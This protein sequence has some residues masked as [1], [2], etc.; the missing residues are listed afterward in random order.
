MKH[1]F[2]CL[3]V[4]F[5]FLFMFVGSFSFASVS[6][7]NFSEFEYN[8]NI[9][10][11]VDW[12][13]DTAFKKT[14]QVYETDLINLNNQNRIDNF[15]LFKTCL[16]D[17]TTYISYYTPC[18]YNGN[19]NKYNGNSSTNGKFN[20]FQINFSNN[21]N[22]NG[23]V[24]YSFQ[25]YYMND[26][27]NCIKSNL[28]S[29]LSINGSANPSTSLSS[30]KY[31]Y[32]NEK[33]YVT[34]NKNT[35]IPP[36]INLKFIPVSNT[37]KNISGIPFYIQ[38]FWRYETNFHIGNIQDF[39]SN[40]SYSGYALLLINGQ[41]QTSDVSLYIAPDG[42]VYVYTSNLLYNQGYAF[43]FFN[44]DLETDI[45]NF[46]FIPYGQTSGDIDSSGDYVY[47]GNDNNNNVPIINQINEN[48][49]FWKNTYDS[50]FA[51]NSGDATEVYNM[52]AS[53]FPSGESPVS[54]Y[55]T[56]FGSLNNEPDD[57]IIRWDSIPFNMSIGG[58][59]TTFSG[60]F[61]QS[62]DI[63]FSELTRTN[64][65]FGIVHFWIRTLATISFLFIA[66]MTLYKCFMLILGVSTDFV[67]TSED[68]RQIGFI[69]DWR[70]KK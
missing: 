24:G 10:D 61:I 1:W 5:L 39:N 31:L 16:N 38:N 37:L 21:T 29:G 17:K 56:I 57:F 9:N 53:Y 41:Y 34:K 36:M 2:S 42:Q 27:P 50:L 48:Q 11:F 59:T 64:H 20:E 25:F 47:T 40:L 67:D 66:W 28:T 69:N 51:M 6:Y 65:T 26:E 33:W 23:N 58:G 62:G 3:L 32:A 60:D 55:D 54:I 68:H 14:L 4:G 19:Y 43:K 22:W 46:Y 45:Y 49:D 8:G 15:N 18:N 35:N 52:I 7:T 13:F 12:A 70:D 30:I 63:N 44:G